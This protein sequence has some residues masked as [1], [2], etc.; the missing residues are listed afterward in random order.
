[1]TRGFPE[2]GCKINSEKTMTN[3]EFEDQVEI[4]LK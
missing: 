1:M 3:I 2:Y 4:F